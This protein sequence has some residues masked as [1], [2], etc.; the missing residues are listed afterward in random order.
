MNMFLFYILGS[1]ICMLVSII[2]KYYIFEKSFQKSDLIEIFGF[3]S[4]S[5][6]L[7]ITTIL[8]LL[9]VFCISVV[10]TFYKTKY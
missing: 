8:F 10:V 3:A 6:S 4:L 7:I 5:W 1:L 2:W 9:I